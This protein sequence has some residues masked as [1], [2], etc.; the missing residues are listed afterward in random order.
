MSCNCKTCIVCMHQLQ[1]AVQHECTYL[2]ATGFT[3]IHCFTHVGYS[4]ALLHLDGCLYLLRH[5]ACCSQAANLS[6]VEAKTVFITVQTDPCG[7]PYLGV[8]LDEALKVWSG[9]CPHF[10]AYCSLLRLVS[11]LW[12][13]MTESQ[14]A[15]ANPPMVDIS[16]QLP[17][18]RWLTSACQ[19]FVT[20]CQ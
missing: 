20:D 9:C 14:L 15:A 5:D 12:R 6:S 11:V 16:W 3:G 19:T 2:H 10:L 1:C 17:P 7:Q 8:A 4:L 13:I 18:H